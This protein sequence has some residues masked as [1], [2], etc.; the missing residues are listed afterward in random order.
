MLTNVQK[1][2]V[3]TRLSDLKRTYGGVNKLGTKAGV[4]GG[5]ISNII[6]GKYDSIS[7]KLWAQIIHNCQIT[8]DGWQVAETTNYKRLRDVINHAR[9]MNWMIGISH[10]AGSGK[11]A[12][13]RSYSELDTTGGV[14]FIEA[15]E[16]AR[17][18]FLLQLCRNLGIAPGKGYVTMHVLGEKV[19]EFFHQRQA[20]RPVLIID[21]ADKLKPS[22]LRYLIPFYNALEDRCAI[23][24]CGT[25]NLEKEIKRGV[26]YNRK[27]YDELDSRLGRQFIHLI[28]AT[29]T[30]VKGVCAANGIDD[31]DISRQIFEEAAPT[32]VSHKGQ[33]LR[34]VEDMRRVKRLV[35]REMLKLQHAS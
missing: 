8:F 24:I 2:Q 26:N 27:G 25:D 28:G 31:K 6:N 33:M 29:L 12:T 9:T 20:Y 7:E 15:K 30:D 23:V 32:R 11:T 13:I 22:A 21:E 5:T 19:I 1:N 10:K 3:A 34:V 4:S 18:E 17:R 16:W 14:F 35:Q